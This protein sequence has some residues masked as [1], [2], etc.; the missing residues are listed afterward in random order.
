MKTR[1]GFI[2]NSS[3]TSFCCLGFK[4]EK[5]DFG[6]DYLAEDDW[7]NQHENINGEYWKRDELLWSCDNYE[8]QEFYL[9][10]LIKMATKLAN[11]NNVPVEEIKLF[12]GEVAC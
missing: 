6:E 9:E 5:P 4:V 3:S 7:D 1:S 11:D 12:V 2:S 8:C 10:E